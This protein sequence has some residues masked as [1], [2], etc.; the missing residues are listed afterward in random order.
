MRVRRLLALFVL[1]VMSLAGTACGWFDSGPGDGYV[2]WDGMN[3]EY[4]EAA[5]SFPYSLPEGVVFPADAYYDPDVDDDSW[6]EAGYGAMQAYAFAECAH[7]SVVVANETADFDAA[8]SALDSA[9]EIYRSPFYQAHVVGSMKPIIEQAR[10]GDFTV[11]NEMY[12][13]DCVGGWMGFK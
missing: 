7:R 4:H 5:A 11:F 6:F 12:Q 10:L 9:V 8:M 13:T 1:L 2:R 3:D